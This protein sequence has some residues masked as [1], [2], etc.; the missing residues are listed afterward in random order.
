MYGLKQG[1]RSWYS[2]IDSYIIHNG[3]QRS[4]CEE[5]LYIKEN[6]QCNV[7]IVFLYVDDL[8]FIGDV[9]IE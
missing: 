7:L 8:I 1:P 4:N 9:D 2:R 3:F 5:N 6:Q